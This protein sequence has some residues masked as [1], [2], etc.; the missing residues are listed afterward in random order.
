MT[1]DDW[2]T[3]WFT[4]GVSA[5]S[6]AVILPPGVAAAWLLARREWPGKS[7][8]ET[9]ISLPLVMPPV[10]T[11]LILLK[12]FGRRGPLGPWLESAGI[13]VIFTW[14]AVVI[15][16]GV[17]SFPLLVRSLRTAIE[18][19]PPRLEQVAQTLG[20][21][22]WRV[23]FTI[24]LPLARR[25]LLAGM[26]LA[27]ARALGE[28]GATIT[29]AGYISGKT[30]TLSLEIHQAILMGEDDR[31]MELL[32]ISTLLAFALVWL[33]GFLAVSKTPRPRAA[34]AKA[35][36]PPAA[37]EP[38]AAA[39]EKAAAATA[40][41]PPSAGPGVE[42]RNITLPLA[43]FT[44][45]ADRSFTSAITGLTGASGS[46]KTSLLEI[47]AGLRRPQQG[48]VMMGG[49]SL[50]DADAGIR[51]PPWRR[52]IGYVPQDQAL[53]PHLTVKQNLLYASRH[54]G[55]EADPA[56][57]RRVVEMLE[58]AP[59]LPRGTAELSG[60]ERGRVA[61]GR[62]LMSRPRLLLLD[63]PLAHLD[64]RLKARALNYLETAAAEFQLPMLFVSHSAAELAALCG[65]V[66]YMERGRLSGTEIPV[67][68]GRNNEA[69][70]L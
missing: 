26:V 61:L 32:G 50:T 62:A 24:T 54:G 12:L 36:Q 18:S 2:Q 15:A 51:V 49:S 7:I 27:F 23:F 30:G 47:I 8:V 6:V 31:A 28:F 40:H 64:D 25:G 48:K 58:I 67:K 52:K 13:E 43:A 55:A 46:G 57:F 59:L 70:V 19:V 60:G 37:T 22:P 35:A 65:E 68:T 33:S 42:V 56:L 3:V 14:K 5:A 63:E 4:A 34:A 45:E 16:L 39:P 11:G 9:L 17:M 41:P 10:A 38:A 44:L 20:A 53:F 21:R 69:A 1:S 66:I 29:L